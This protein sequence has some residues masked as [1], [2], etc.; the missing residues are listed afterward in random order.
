MKHVKLETKSDGVDSH[1]CP[2]E[3]ILFFK[4]QRVGTQLAIHVTDHGQ[5]I[6]VVFGSLGRVTIRQKA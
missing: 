1:R 6:A 2:P 5:V 3:R 4:I